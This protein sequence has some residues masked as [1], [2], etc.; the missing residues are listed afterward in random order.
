MEIVLR[1]EPR[2]YVIIHREHYDKL[3]KLGVLEK[4][5]NNMACDCKEGERHSRDFR[6]QSF[7]DLI[8]VS[9]IWD[10]TPEGHKYWSEIAIK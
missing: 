3:I 6:Q 4:W 7:N 9:F 5:K 8:G 1:K 10:D 2:C